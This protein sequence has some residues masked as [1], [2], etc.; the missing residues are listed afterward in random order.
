M[1]LQSVF[2]RANCLKS[3][4]Q[5]ANETPDDSTKIQAYKDELASLEELI[6][7]A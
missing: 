7:L 1:S 2:Q 6:E 5:I 3:W 4:I